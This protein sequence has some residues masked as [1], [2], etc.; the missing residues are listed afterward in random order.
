MNWKPKDLKKAAATHNP[1]F[2]TFLANQVHI[3]RPHKTPKKKSN[4]A[5]QAS[6][7]SVIPI[8]CVVANHWPPCALPSFVCSSQPNVSYKH[9]PVVRINHLIKLEDPQHKES[10]SRLMIW[11]QRTHNVRQLVSVICSM[12]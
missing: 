9:N 1:S 5:Q 2:Y 3:E 4:R 12:L 10:E 8:S 7:P 11:N 6:K